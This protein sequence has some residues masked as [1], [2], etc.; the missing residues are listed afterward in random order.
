MRQATLR[1]LTALVGLGLLAVY[2]GA[3]YL[4]YRLLAAVWLA[5][6][7]VV[8]LVAW[9][10]LF[11]VLLSYL[12]YRFGTGQ[13]LARM[14]AVDSMLREHV[15]DTID[16]AELARAVELLRVGAAA[17][18]ER[19]EGRPLFAGHAG[20]DWPDEPH[21]ALWHAQTLL[22][23]YRGDGH[24]AALTAA[25]LTGCEALVAHGATGDVPW[26]MLR[27]TRR[28]TE[29]DWDRAVESLRSRGWLDAS[30]E[31]TEAGRLA[32]RGIEDHTDLLAVTPYAAIGEAGCEELRTLARPWST[33]M[34]GTLP[35]R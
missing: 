10:T 29:A 34:A 19:P 28:R 14:E 8:T 17:A 23:E 21:L 35:T 20:L 6:T 3:A 31:F 16:S 5:R 27:A 22:R 1:L 12:S 15:L 30:G 26:K 32:R 9:T 18:C 24:V 33:L 13:L 11:A 2:A 25:G 7:D 4:G